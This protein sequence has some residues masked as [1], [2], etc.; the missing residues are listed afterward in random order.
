MHRCSVCGTTKAKAN[1]SGVQWKK[2]GTGKCMACA[3]AAQNASE[4]PPRGRGPGHAHC[5]WPHA[6]LPSSIHEALDMLTNASDEEES[7]WVVP[8]NAKSAALPPNQGHVLKCK[9]QAT[10]GVTH[11]GRWPACLTTSFRS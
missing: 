2:E 9:E 5:H 4:E 8:S 7:S 1:F 10:R 11:D 6:H 3:Q